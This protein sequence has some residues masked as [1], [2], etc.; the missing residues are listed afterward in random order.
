MR[1]SQRKGCGLRSITDT[2]H[3]GATQHRLQAGVADQ[4]KAAS[5]AAGGWYTTRSGEATIMRFNKQAAQQ[6]MKKVSEQPAL[7]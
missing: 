4:F 1:V 6:H 3:A 7:I 2:H 5:G